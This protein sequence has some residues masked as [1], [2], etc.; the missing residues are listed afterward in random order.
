MRPGG[1]QGGRRGAGKE[2]IPRSLKA[3][4]FCVAGGREYLTGF[5]KRKVERRKAA[6]EEIKRK[7]KEEQRKMKEEVREGSCVPPRQGGQ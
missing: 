3:G 1:P 4:G 7:L 6:L 2:G 5:H